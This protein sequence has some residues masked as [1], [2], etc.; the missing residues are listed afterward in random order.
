MATSTR[1][2]IESPLIYLDQNTIR[3]DSLGHKKRFRTLGR[4]RQFRKQQ[5]Y[6]FMMV[7]SKGIMEQLTEFNR[8]LVDLE[9][10]GVHLKDEDTDVRILVIS[11][12]GGV[13]R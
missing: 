8:S 3:I 11:L 12:R 13:A 7:E 6:S 2:G 4:I 1:V 10:I 9:N 5:L